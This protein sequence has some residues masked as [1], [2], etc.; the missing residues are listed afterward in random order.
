[1]ALTLTQNFET[2]LDLN[3]IKLVIKNDLF[4]KERIK[5]SKVISFESSANTSTVTIKKLLEIELASNISAMVSN[6]FEI[7]ESWD[8]ENVSKILVLVEIPKV[9]TKIV[10]ELKV[11][12]QHIIEVKSQINSTVFMMGSFV[13][14][15]VAK[16][17]KKIVDKDLKILL[18]WPINQI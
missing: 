12:D 2:N 7:F 14:E 6:P 9:Q 15:H 5:D 1:M 16:F 8:L 10:V 11:N 18:S 17:W 4:Q 3:Q 13:E